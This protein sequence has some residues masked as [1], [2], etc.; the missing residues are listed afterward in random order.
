VKAT[1]NLLVEG[2]VVVVVGGGVVVVVVVGG[3]VVVVVVLVRNVVEVAVVVE[4]VVEFVGLTMEDI[5][6]TG[7]KRSRCCNRQQNR[8]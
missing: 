4:L 3:G 5:S 1:G 6:A 8:C 2:L 7:A